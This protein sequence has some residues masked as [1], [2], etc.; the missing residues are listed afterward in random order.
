[1]PHSMGIFPKSSVSIPWQRGGWNTWGLDPKSVQH[2]NLRHT[3][4]ILVKIC[5]IRSLAELELEGQWSNPQTLPSIY[6]WATTLETFATVAE[7]RYSVSTV[8]N[9]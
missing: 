7:W 2:D 1:M 5:S 9:Y 6:H 8:Q 4:D 3:Y